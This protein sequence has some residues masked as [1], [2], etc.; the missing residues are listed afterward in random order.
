MASQ[1]YTHNTLKI[2]CLIEPDQNKNEPKIIY[3]KNLDKLLSTIVR[4]FPFLEAMNDSDWSICINSQIMDKRNSFQFSSV[5]STLPPP[6]VVYVITTPSSIATEA[7]GCVIVVHLDKQ[8]FEYKLPQDQEHWSDDMYDKLL[9]RINSQFKLHSSST[10]SFSLQGD[11]GVDIDDMDD[12]KDQFDD[13]VR[14]IDLF[15]KVMLMTIRNWLS[16]NQLSDI[17]FIANVAS[18][19]GLLSMDTQ[20]LCA[21]LPAMGLNSQQIARLTQALDQER[22]PKPRVQAVH[23]IEQKDPSHQQPKAL[24]PSND[25]VFTD[26]NSGKRYQRYTTFKGKLIEMPT[27]SKKGKMC[28][29]Y[30]KEF[31]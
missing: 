26:K 9:L 14:S 29:S 22:Q 18:L 12:I 11:G 8:R 1:A 17:Q 3:F 19:D 21:C 24:N 13:E 7:D 10:T 2:I 28:I 25:Q 5:L 31:I 20:T 15:V 30:G 4:K 16:A 23:P 6:L 27:E